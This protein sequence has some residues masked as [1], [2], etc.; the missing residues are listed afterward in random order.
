MNIE[1]RAK[2]QIRKNKLIEELKSLNLTLAERCN[3]ED[4]LLSIKMDLE[5]FESNITKQEDC[6]NCGS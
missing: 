3:H 2:K 5:E 4:E 1:E 6:E